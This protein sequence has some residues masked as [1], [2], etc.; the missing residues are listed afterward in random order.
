MNPI[1]LATAIILSPAC[2][3]ICYKMQKNGSRS[4]PFA[5]LSVLGRS[6]NCAAGLEAPA[7]L[8]NSIYIISQSNYSDNKKSPGE[9]GQRKG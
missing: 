5:V 9:P 7:C 6:S 1:D 3:K 4:D 2:Y 8:L